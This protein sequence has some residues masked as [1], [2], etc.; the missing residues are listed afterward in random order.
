[1]FEDLKKIYGTQ[2]VVRLTRKYGRKTQRSNRG[3]FGRNVNIHFQYERVQSS[4]N[5]RSIGISAEI[6]GI[7]HSHLSKWARSEAVHLWHKTKQPIEIR[8][9][10]RH[11][12]A[13]V[14]RLKAN[15]LNK[16]RS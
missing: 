12:L 1:M 4:F 5:H 16:S 7:L 14:P 10:I 2:S 8:T 9:Q 13:L 15:C 6:S 11:H 3:I